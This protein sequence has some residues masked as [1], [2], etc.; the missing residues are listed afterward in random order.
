MQAWLFPTAAI[1][2]PAFLDRGPGFDGP[3]IDRRDR[4]SRDQPSHC[5]NVGLQVNGDGAGAAPPPP[6]GPPAPMQAHILAE[7]PGNAVV[8]EPATVR[9]L[10]SRNKIKDSAGTVS[11]GTISKSTKTRCSPSRSCRNATWW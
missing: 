3:L 11:D 9:V 4:H 10:L 2:P 7:M 1:A 5:P 6:P 8:R